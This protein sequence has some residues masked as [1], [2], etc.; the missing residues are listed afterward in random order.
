MLIGN[1][2]KEIVTGGMKKYRKQMLTGLLIVFVIYAVLLLVFDASGQFQANEGLWVALRSFPLWLVPILCLTQIGAAFFRFIEWHYYLGVI[3]ARDKIS[4]K[5]SLIMFTASFMMVVSPGK[6]AEVLKS[7]LLKMKTGVSIARSAPVVIAERVVDGLAV[8]VVLI[9]VLIVVPESLDLGEYEAI[10]K[11]VLYTAT[12]LLVGGLIAVQIKPLAYFLLNMLAKIPFVNRLHEPLTEFYESSREIFLLKHVI[13]TS[14]MGLGVY[15][16]STIGFV[17]IMWG[18]GLTITPTLILKLTFIVGI[19]SAI[20]ALSF[21][22]NGAGV[23]EFTN[24]AMLSTLV[25]PYHPELTIGMMGA[26]ALM[27]SFFHKWFRVLLGAGV[28]LVYR[29]R[30]FTQDLEDEIIRM[31][32][33][34]SATPFYEAV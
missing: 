32:A 31:E 27:Q 15:A 1:D 10:S 16:C 28:A 24:Y 14:I 17:L 21:I 30:L 23:T 34:K 20:G 18:F 25:A 19:A 26:A 3:D 2:N 13:P 33:E 5:D 9:L 6:V 4:L 11:G 8:V 7:V 22:P 29:K 12:G